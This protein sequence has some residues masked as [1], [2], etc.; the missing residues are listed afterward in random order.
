MTPRTQQRTLRLT[1]PLNLMA[2]VG[3]LRHG[4]DPSWARL[5]SGFVKATLTP[6]GPGCEVVEVDAGAGEV[7][8]VAAG[9]GAPW[10]AERLPALLGEDDDPSGF[11]PPAP[12]REHWR[13]RPGIR[14]P[15]T[16]LVFESFVP[17]VLG[18]KVTGAEATASYRR[19][20]RRLAEP[21]GVGP[22]PQLLVP[23][24]A[25]VWRGVPSWLWHEAGVG[26][27]RS[28][29][30]AAAAKRADAMERL[31]GRSPEQARF[32]LQSLPGVGVWTAAEVAQ[33]V[34]GDA[35]AISVGDFHVARSVV[36][37]ITGARDG[38]DEQM[39]ELLT[40]CSG[41]RF[42]VQRLV[43]VA[44]L[45]PPRRGPRYRGRDFRGM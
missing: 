5:P 3:P 45:G 2:T 37:A 23:P 35:D 11:S 30:I 40:G 34:W 25:A 22:M 20:L 29:V 13:R 12:L 33:R 21:I 36:Y 31:T 43:E 27:D 14:V 6:D 15:A 32:A 24:P 1:S 38:T 4:N 26:P 41:H 16:G 9:P 39:V 18:Q 10:L 17:V 19:L 28:R 42:R 44:R 8:Q 7:R